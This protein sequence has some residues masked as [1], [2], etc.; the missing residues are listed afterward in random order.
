MKKTFVALALAATA[1]AGLAPTAF[2][3]TR[4]DEDRWRAAQR[5]YDEERAIYDRERAR[6][7]AAID[8]DRRYGGSYD[9]RRYNDDRY[10]AAQD[11]REGR[12][13]ERPL[14][15]NDQVYRGSDGRYY[16]RRSDGTVGLVVGAGVGA[17][18]GRAVDTRGERG[19][20]TILGGTLGALLGRSVE[21]SSDV[22]CR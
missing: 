17:L 11:Y 6:Y 16:C 22:R 9:D 8:R 20:G 15:A 4:A 7:D 5:R 14:G 2:A 1:V 3:Q 19:T 13:A 21:R 12:Y 18:L 10:D